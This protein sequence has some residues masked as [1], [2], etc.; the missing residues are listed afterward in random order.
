MTTGER[1][2]ENWMKEDG[3]FLNT[4]FPG[5]ADPSWGREAILPPVGYSK[6]N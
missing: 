5:G 1:Q 2:G 6:L 4:S 3:V